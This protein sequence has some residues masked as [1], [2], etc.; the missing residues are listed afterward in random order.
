[1]W[2]SPS[3]TLDL[4]SRDVIGDESASGVNSVLEAGRVKESV[5]VNQKSKIQN[6]E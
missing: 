6:H 1:M 2:C 3:E 5:V 4:E